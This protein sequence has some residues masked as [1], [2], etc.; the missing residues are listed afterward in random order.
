MRVSGKRVR[1]AGKE[2]GGNFGDRT[3]VGMVERGYFT[4]DC[5]CGRDFGRKVY[6][7]QASAVFRD[8]E[9]T[10]RGCVWQGMEVRIVHHAWDV[11]AFPKDTGSGRSEFGKGFCRPDGEYGAERDGIRYIRP[12]GGDPELVDEAVEEIGDAPCGDVR[13]AYRRLYGQCHGATRIKGEAFLCRLWAENDD[14]R[15]ATD[16]YDVFGAVVHPRPDGWRRAAYGFFSAHGL[17]C[18]IAAVISEEEEGE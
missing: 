8:I 10:C 16:P 15:L 13:P 11:P 14:R 2:P 7:V 17:D 6:G 12:F 1:Y 5:P 3:R 4:G 18:T 9:E